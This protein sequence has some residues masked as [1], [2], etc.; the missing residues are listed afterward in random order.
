MEA[1]GCFFHAE[2]FRCKICE[3]VLEG[4]A[5]VVDVNDDVYCVK[6]FQVNLFPRCFICEHL[7]VPQQGPVHT[8]PQQQ[9]GSMHTSPQ[10]Q[11]GSLHI[12][13]MGKDFHL[14]CYKC[15]SCEVLLVRKES[16]GCYPLGEHIFCR[17]CYVEQMEGS[18]H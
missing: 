3:G 5:S 18:G 6:C 15:H 4:V 11:Q 16:E 1:C 7:I 8:T 13:S 17:R 9:Q 14:Q 12:S 2:C 10:Q